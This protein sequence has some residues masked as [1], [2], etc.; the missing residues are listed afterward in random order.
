LGRNSVSPHC[1]RWLNY[2]FVVPQE[3]LPTEM[4][5]FPRRMRDWLFTVMAE[6]ADR[7]EL[8]PHYM[9][10]QREAESNLTRRWTNAAVWKFCDLD[11]HPADR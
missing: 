6:M 11:G 5:D 1:V 7:E 2:V 9:A 3:C 10:M 4:A 8:S